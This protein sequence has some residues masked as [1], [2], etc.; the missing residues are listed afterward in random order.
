MVTGLGDGDG[1]VPCGD[2]LIELGEALAQGEALRLARAREG[3]SAAL[4]PEAAVDAVAVA[5]MFNAITRVAD[6]TGIPL[7]ESTAARTGEMRAKLGID[8][9]ERRLPDVEPSV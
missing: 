2:L 8:A 6:A 1:G 7:D 9:F 5:S 4:G 3:I